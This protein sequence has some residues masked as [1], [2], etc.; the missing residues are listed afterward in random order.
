MSSTANHVPPTS[1]YCHS[2]RGPYSPWMMH[3]HSYN[4][5]TDCQSPIWHHSVPPP[6]AQSQTHS[7]NPHYFPLYNLPSSNVNPEMLQEFLQTQQMLVNTICKC[8]ELLWSQQKEINTL[9]N[10]VLWL[11]EKFIAQ[12]AN[13]TSANLDNLQQQIRGESVPPLVA[14]P[15]NIPTQY[16]SRAQSEQPPSL[17]TNTGTMSPLRSGFQTYGHLRQQNTNTSS[18]SSRPPLPTHPSLNMYQNYPNYFS[19]Q[20]NDLTT[21]NIQQSQQQQQ[22]N[23][24]PPQQPTILNN[25]AATL[26]QNHDSPPIFMHHNNNIAMSNNKLMHNLNIN[27]ASSGSG[28]TTGGGGGTSSSAFNAREP[29]ALNNQVPPGNRANNYWDNFRR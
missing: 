19:L 13:Q 22:Q 2:S 20:Q 9:N 11:Q 14:G 29:S 17:Y 4:A 25:N 21:T 8:N 10:A 6:P 12:S 23:Q 28:A 5:N 27:A 15:L 24:V 16:Y 3:H 26:P 1:G 18:T 7:D